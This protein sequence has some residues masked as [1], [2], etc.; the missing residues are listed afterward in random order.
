MRYLG[1][2]SQDPFKYPGSG[3]DW[4]SHLKKFGNDVETE[5]LLQSTDKSEINQLGRYYSALWHITTAA[6]DF[7]NKIWA[8]RIPETGGGGPDYF[9]PPHKRPEV[10]K[11]MSEKASIASNDP[12]IKEKKMASQKKAFAR[13]EHR[14]I[15]SK[16][17]KN[18]QN[19]PEVAEKRSKTM[20]IVQ[21]DPK[22]KEKRS[23]K[24][25]YRYDHT[26]RHFIHTSGVEEHCTQREL[27]DKYGLA[28]QLVS[29][30]VTGKRNHHKGWKIN[31]KTQCM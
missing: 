18:A 22:E 7:G 23:G 21:N 30:V 9:D 3:V 15:R 12:I 19:R 13:P 17:Q 31:T 8:N 10:R 24:N 29:K 5:I 14:D 2:T 6:D 27:V 28:Q 20:S 25:S 11:K 1:Q 16:A 4:V 26:I